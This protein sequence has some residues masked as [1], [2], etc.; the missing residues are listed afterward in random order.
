MFAGL[1]WDYN[2]ASPG[3]II[4]QLLGIIGCV[5]PPVAEPQKQ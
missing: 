1:S 4:L 5:T 2:T 3:A